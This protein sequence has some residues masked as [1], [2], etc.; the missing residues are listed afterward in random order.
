M[1]G[2]DQK[3]RRKR[4][5]LVRVISL[6]FLLSAIWTLLSFYLILS[7]T[8]PLQPAQKAYFD[9]LTPIDYASTIVVGLLNMTAAVMLFLLRRIAR[10]LF[11]AS[12]GISFVLA[13]LHTTTK[14]WAEALGGP[15]LIGALIGYVLVIGVCIYAWRL[16][17]RGVLH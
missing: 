8:I 12:F 2:E 4:P 15:G 3:V 17:A 16:S 7:G 9:G 6:F 1:T 10:D 13:V 14:G 11:L 5:I